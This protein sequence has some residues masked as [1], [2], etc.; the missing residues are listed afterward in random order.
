MKEVQRAYF[1][2]EKAVKLQKHR[3]L[4]MLISVIGEGHPYLSA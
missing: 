2:Q 3:L 4:F 1:S